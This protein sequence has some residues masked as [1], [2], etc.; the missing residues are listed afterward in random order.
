MWLPNFSNKFGEIAR[1]FKK[2]ENDIDSAVFSAA[3]KKQ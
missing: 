1:N 3:K 2:K